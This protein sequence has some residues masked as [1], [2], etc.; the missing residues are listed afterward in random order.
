MCATESWGIQR[1]FHTYGLLQSSPKSHGAQRFQ[2]FS[3]VGR[4]QRACEVHG[5][6]SAVEIEF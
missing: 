1:D 3:S 6:K 2:D 5:G 4:I